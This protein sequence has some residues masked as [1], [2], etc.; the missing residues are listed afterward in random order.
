MALPLKIKVRWGYVI[1]FVLLLISYFLIFFAI[2]KVANET[3]WVTHSYMVINTLESLRGE[4]ANAETGARGYVITK[5]DRFLDPYKSGSAS[6][7]NH[8]DTLK[9]LVDDNKDYTPLVDSLGMLIHRKLSFIAGALQL[10]NANGGNITPEL[11]G[12]AEA[13][14]S[15]MDSIR[16]LVTQL[17]A[18][19][20]SLRNSRNQKLE[21]FFENTKIIAVT[22]LLL[23]LFTVIYSLLIYDRE[24]KAKESAKANA[25]DYSKQ[26]E[27]RVNELNKVNAE[28]QELRSIEK[29]ASTGRIS[30]TIAHEV[31]N[32][33]TNISL[34]TEQLK[35]ITGQ[36][37]DAEILLEMV[38]RNA[39]RI[40]Q[41]VSELLNSTRF[42]QLEYRFADVNQLLDESLDQAKDRIELNQVRVEK[43]YDES[44]GQ[45]QVDAEKMK[46]AFLNIIVNAIEAM[47]KETGVLQINSRQQN[48][49]CIIEFKDNGQ[50]M[51]QETQQK[52]FEPYFTSKAKGNGLGLTNTQ[53][54]I[55]NH[56]GSITVK[57]APG[58]GSSFIIILNRE[59][60]KKD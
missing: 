11:R 2:R 25:N 40:N 55:L 22:S 21:S 28:L 10:F 42:A 30:R 20:R 51:D 47:P 23:A 6:A 26:L 7:L 14:K 53:N 13:S 50:G 58:Q 57:S 8:Y 5:D 3:R 12:S 34:A 33:L 54:I 15:A 17:Q 49:K 59:V 39:S 52:L 18:K 16:L 32:P 9:L 37:P 44:L 24:S 36:T 4:M 41:L 38:S 31:R 48:N 46:L 29:F 1:A 19:E 27:Q 60:E 56:G 43:H 35:E 45:I